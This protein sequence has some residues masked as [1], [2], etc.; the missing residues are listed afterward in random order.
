VVAVTGSGFDQPGAFAVDTV[1]FTG[2]GGIDTETADFHVVSDTEIWT[3]VPA[4]A[5]T[6]AITVTDVG[7]DAA[8]SGVFTVSTD[9][10][11]CGPTITSFTPMCG[12]VGTVVTITGTNLLSDSGEDVTPTDPT[13]GVVGFN[14]YTGASADA[15]HTGAAESPTTLVVN[16]P[17]NAVDGPI[18]VTTNLSV[19]DDSVDSTDHFNVVTDPL[20]C[21]VTG[22]HAR[23]INL[24]LRGALT[25]KGRVRSSDD[26]A[27]CTDNVQV[28]I[29]RRQSGKW[30][31]I[32]ITNTDTVGK[33]AKKIRNRSGKYR[34]IAPKFTLENGEVCLK[35]KSNRVKYRR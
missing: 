4:A 30:K 24:R 1:N 20:E 18:R 19:G 35:A 12:V 22:D 32:K 31:T 29:Q 27:A 9:E 15:N 6:G 23:T 2:A 5:T 11:G 26:T 8:N 14:P 7:G 21:G 17:G 10:G 25:A 16:V 13:G 28:K 33:Y 3:T 34:S